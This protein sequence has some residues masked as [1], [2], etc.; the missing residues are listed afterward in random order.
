MLFLMSIL[1]KD[2]PSAILGAMMREPEML[3]IDSL[4]E[5]F[6]NVDGDSA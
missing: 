1:K 4:M 2:L 3:G 5:A 6:K